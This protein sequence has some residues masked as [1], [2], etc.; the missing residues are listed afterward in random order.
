MAAS[1][2]SEHAVHTVMSGP[3]AAAIATGQAGFTE[4]ITGDMGGSHLCW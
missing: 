4:V 3:A 1:L 2:I